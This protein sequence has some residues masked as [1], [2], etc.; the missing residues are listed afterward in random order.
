M[1]LLITGGTGF[2]GSAVVEQLLQRGDCIQIVS[3]NTKK[4]QESSLVQMPAAGALFSEKVIASFD[5]IINLAGESIAGSRWDATIRKRILNSRV[6]ATSCIVDSIRRNQE[7]GLPFP[8]VL[9][10]AS[11]IGYYGT[12]PQQRFTESSGS[13]YGFLADVCRAWELEAVKGESLGIRVVR[14]RLGHVLER[15]GGMLPRVATPFSFGMGGYLGDGQQWISWI[16]RKDL[17][18]IIIQALDNGA[19]QGVYNAC[20][21]YAVTMREFMEVLGTTLGS[22]SRTRIPALL[23]RI[24]FGEMAEEVLLKGQ[25]VYPKRLLQQG[26]PFQYNQLSEALADIYPRN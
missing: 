17:V 21:P 8:K 25:K 16:H 24:L 11:A 4:K 1:N 6:A 26:Y 12:H 13:G 18:N 2:I 14:L 5:G 10:N 19:W 23:A 20:T 15:D 9:V 3:R 7:R 22:K